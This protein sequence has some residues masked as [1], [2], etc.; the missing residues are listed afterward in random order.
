MQSHVPQ[1]P[2]MPSNCSPTSPKSSNALLSGSNKAKRIRSAKRRSRCI[3]D[4]GATIHCIKDRSLFTHLDTDTSVRIRVANNQVLCSEG[5]GTCAVRLVNTQGQAHT[6][7]LQ[8]CVYS[9][10]FSDN[11]ISTRRL[12]K[13]N[14]IS[15][16]FGSV[17]YMKCSATKSRY[18]FNSDCSHDFVPAARQA[19]FNVD[20]HLLHSRFNHCGSHRLHKMFEHTEGLGPP[21]PHSHTHNT[22]DCPACLEGAQRRRAFAKRKD[23]QYSYFGEKLSSDLCGPFPKSVDGFTYA[24]CFVDAYTN[25]CAIYLLQSKSAVEVK[26]SFQSFLKDYKQY[27][28]HG[29]SV[30]WHTD[31][32]KEFMSHSLD[33]FCEEFAVRRSFSVPYAPPQNSQAERMWGILLKPI[34]TLLAQSRIDDAFWSFAIRHACQC[35]NVMPSY[36]QPGMRSPYEAL[37]GQKPDVSKFRVWGCLT[38]YLA[39]DHEHESKLSPRAWPAIHLGFD[40]LRNGYIVYVP[41]K[42]RITTGW[43][44]VFQEH[45]FLQVSPTH[46]SGMPRVPKPVS[47]P[48]MLYKEPRDL[49]SPAPALP[50]AQLPTPAPA[51][52]AP[53][54][55][56]TTRDRGS[57]SN[58]DRESES[59]SDRPTRVGTY[60]PVPPRNTRNQNPAYINVISDD[61]SRHAFKIDLDAI[62]NEI[63]T[64]STYTEAINSKLRDRWIASMEL[65]IKNLIKHD[66][67][68]LV[69]LD[70]VPAGQ[71]IVKSKFVYAIKRNRDGSIERFKSR[72]VACGYSQVK[73]IDYDKTFSATLRST[74][75]RLLMAISAG[76]KLRLDHFD[77]TSAFTQSKIDT[78]IYVEAPPGNF[79]SKDEKGR[80]KVLKLKKAL[81]GTKQ[82]SK[83]WQDT[84]VNHLTKNMGFKQ[85]KNDPCLFIKD[86][87]HGMMIV[88]VYVD[89]IIA[90]HN[91]PSMLAWFKE[92]FTGS[93]GFNAT[94]LGTL[95][96]FLGMA[97]DQAPDSSI[98]VHQTK[99]IEKMLGKFVPSHSTSSRTHTMPCN[100]ETFQRLTKARSDEERERLSRLPY[101]EIVGSLLYL[102]CMTRPDIAYHMS[103]LCS[104][105]HDPSI[106]CYNAAI[107]L[108]LYVGHT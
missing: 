13:D 62:V 88:G 32:G 103:V 95:S 55:P 49:K 74:S 101:L 94:H 46:I 68:E 58:S 24:L 83:L 17:N 12:W 99:Y 100:P 82:A 102:S 91:S 51:P 52:A 76:K 25:F 87:E 105:M 50:P 98:T 90:A 22:R 44:V 54:R 31:N 86:D 73:G 80:P 56:Q 33:E 23:N 70:D 85:L 35:H 67:W 7:V 38:W 43:H 69:V 37:T 61:V 53:A 42:N 47:R 29:K 81:Y 27:F 28:S 4:S 8:N 64:P 97:V 36:A 104:Y 41:H 16:H 71:R 96:W 72:F 92:E 26:Q 107:D 93:R 34:R 45:R 2:P 11:L 19:D 48:Q 15:T 79:V 40:P 65:E 6:V 77:V 60:G 89:D 108:L 39:P 63:P 9:P 57:D 78:D 10:F 106:D 1:M 84:L 18:H 21:P 59:S 66:T 3:V 75:F 5:V 30:T 14:K 20:M